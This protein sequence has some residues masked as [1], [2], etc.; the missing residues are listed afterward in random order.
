MTD[1]NG[2]QPAYGLRAVPVGYY[3]IVASPSI[4]IFEKS[5]SRSGEILLLVEVTDFFWTQ[6]FEYHYW[7]D[8]PCSLI[9]PFKK[10]RDYIS[11]ISGSSLLP[12]GRTVTYTTN[13]P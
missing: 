11:D 1:L 2:L 4:R 8:H 13:P 12:T 6:K 9:I 10:T 3:V 5:R 7:V